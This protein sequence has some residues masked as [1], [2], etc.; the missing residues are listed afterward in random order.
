MA[1]KKQHRKKTVNFIQLWDTIAAAFI[2]K[3]NCITG[4]RR[5]YN[6]YSDIIGLYSGENNV[7]YLYTIDGFPRE[8]SN[9]IFEQLRAVCKNGVRISFVEDL[10]HTKIDWTSAQMK[11]KLR[12]WRAID[13]EIEDVDEYNLYQNMN[14]LDSQNW[15]KDSLVYLSTAE[16]RRQRKMF[17]FRVLM[18]ISGSRDTQENVT[19]FNNTVK[20]VVS[21]MKQLNISYS[22]I[23]A[24]IPQYIKFFSPFSHIYDQDTDKKIGKVTLPDE[25]ISHFNTYQQGVIGKEGIYWG[26]DIYSRFPTFKKPKLNA[27]S[28]ENWFITAETGG[29]KSYFVKGLLLQLLALPDING[30]IMDI[31]GFEYRPLLDIVN[32]PDINEYASEVNM[33]E[34]SGKY[35]DP[36]EIYLTGDPTL[37]SDMYSLSTSFTLSI[38]RC[39]LGDVEDTDG[40][41]DIVITDAVAETYSKRGVI[42]EDKTT[43]RFSKGLTLFDVYDTLKSLKSSGNVTRAINATYAH[44]MWEEKNMYRGKALSQNDV[45]RLITANEGY[46]KA[47]D[48][49]IA[50]VSRYFE[51]NGIRSTLFKDRITIDDVK[52]AKLIICSFGMAGK[53]QDSVDAIQMQL[54]QLYAANI[55]HLRSIFSRNQGKYNFKL[56]EEFQR[57]GGF[58]GADKTI[59]VALTGGRKL[60]DIN[61]I[62]TNKVVDMLQ[63]DKFGIF[64]TITSFAIG[65]II[66]SHVRSKLCERLSIPQMTEELDTINKNNKDL[67]SYMTGDTLMQSPYKKAFLIG[68]DR[69]AYTITRMVIPKGLEPALFETG[70][71]KADE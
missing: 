42:E 58:P 28:P 13:E 18:L 68:L 2:G 57:W 65:A 14:M 51:P 27:T 23:T 11:A 21:A 8:V 34:G 53:S 36:V 31:E 48:I 40:W 39:L 52:D 43:W 64:S 26:T 22:R 10:E 24:D 35:Y 17:K 41:V 47:I 55:S 63:D 46:Q 12:T 5:P 54:M 67:T 20:D 49:C 38:F 66:D 19:N 45:N 16:L 15:R 71:K 9:A 69:T 44:S 32:D 29:G 3:D 59:N 30:T 37:D 6:I 25:L 33:G 50:K 1:K 56:W 7:T 4:E 70:V 62:I 61:I 60:G